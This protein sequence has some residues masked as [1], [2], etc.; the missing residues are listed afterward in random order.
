MHRR[1][2]FHRSLRNV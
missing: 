2:H 1:H